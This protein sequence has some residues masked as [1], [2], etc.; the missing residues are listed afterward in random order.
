MRFPDNQQWI[1]Q[2]EPN[3][4]NLLGYGR[5]GLF[6]TNSVEINSIGIC[7]RYL[8]LSGFIVDEWFDFFREISDD[9]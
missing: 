8:P 3:L 4:S 5:S 6:G 9:P 2:F 7:T 1:P